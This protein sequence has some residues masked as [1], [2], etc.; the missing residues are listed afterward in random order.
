MD[1]FASV[2]WRPATTVF[3]VI[4]LS[5][6][7]IGLTVAYIINHFDFQPTVE[8]RAG[9][10]V[11]QVT[12]ADT[13]QERNKGLSGVDA[14]SPNGG[15]LMI[16]ESDAQWGIWM[17]DMK[18]PLDIV[19][20]NKDKQIVYIVKN[21]PPEFST[22]TTPSPKSPARYVLELPQG[23]VETAGIK[24]GQTVTFETSEVQ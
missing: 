21:V 8:V 1:K 11:Y 6:V 17:K 22:S 10:G 23:S 20:L 19:W 14:L 15:L 3:L 16:Y 18:I 24:T 9:S 12:I 4:G 13:D 7:L 2:R 5:L